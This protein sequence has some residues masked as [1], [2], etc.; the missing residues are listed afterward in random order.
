MTEIEWHQDREGFESGVYRI[1]RIPESPRD[2]WRLEIG[3][4]AARWRSGRTPVASSHATLGGAKDAAGRAEREQLLQD[5]MIGH[6]IVGAAAFVVFATLLPLMESLNAFAVAMVAFYVGLRSFTDAISIRLG[7]AW[8]WTRDG[9]PKIE[10]LKEL[11][12]DMPRLVEIIKDDQ[13]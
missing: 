6:S 9:V 12:I 3:G 7:D 5:R 11:G 1:R 13:E 4:H 8:G 10:R 2:R